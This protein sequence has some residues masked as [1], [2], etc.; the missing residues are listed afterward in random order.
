MADS[1]TVETSYTV[2]VLPVTV[3]GNESIIS[4]PW[5]E[6]GT[7][8][9]SITVSNI[10]KTANL[11]ENDLLLWYDPSKKYFQVWKVSAD[12]EWVPATVVS[13]IQGVSF[14][15]GEQESLKRG[16][17]IILRRASA[18]SDTIYIVGGEGSD[19]AR[20]AVTVAKGTRALIAPP[21]VVSTNLYTVAN[22]HGVITGAGWG[23]EIII[24]PTSKLIKLTSEW[25]H[26][27]TSDNWV[28]PEPDN[29]NTATVSAGQGLIYISH[30]GANAADDVTI[31]F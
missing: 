21:Y 31:N 29:S 8:L 24:T 3:S 27:T 7:S 6:S 18:E 12:K 25:K 19:V 22:A 5:I 17:A 28:T 2:G 15:D 9:D 4:I 10:V 1:T 30:G 11:A 26:Y 13:N 16:E 14:K 20:S 23:D